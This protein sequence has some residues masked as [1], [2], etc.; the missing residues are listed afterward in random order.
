MPVPYNDYDIRA[1]QALATGTA[2]ELQQRRVLDWWINIACG[3]Y[4]MSFRPGAEDGHRETD[5]AEG[6]R[7][8]G[9]Q[10]V[11]LLKAKPKNQKENL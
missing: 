7:F 1:L 3:T 10:T 2:S 9:S 11:K 5:F 6:R 8:V 4:D